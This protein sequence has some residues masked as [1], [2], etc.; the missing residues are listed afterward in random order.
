V[1]RDPPNMEKF[2][3]VYFIAVAYSVLLTFNI[4][5]NNRNEYGRTLVVDSAEL[6]MNHLMQNYSPCKGIK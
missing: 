1:K 3:S 6:H 4:F 2:A 5:S